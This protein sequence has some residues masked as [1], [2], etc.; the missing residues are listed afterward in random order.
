MT[1]DDIR[2][3]FKKKFNSNVA[4]L[5]K[6][7]EKMEEEDGRELKSIK[8]FASSKP[9]NFP[10]D[11]LLTTLG[12]MFEKPDIQAQIWRNQRSVHGLAKVKAGKKSKKCSWSSKSQELE[13]VGILWCADNHIYNNTTDFV[14][15]EE[16][17]TY[18][19]HS[20]LKSRRRVNVKT[21]STLIKIQK[22]LVK[23]KEAADVDTIVAT[24]TTESEYVAAAYCCG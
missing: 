10:D 21:A 4:F 5:E 13:A 11:F 3:I 1:Y 9:N 2:P 7:R 8:R 14:S 18:Q 17:S 24:S 6:I 15:R 22:P 20:Q 19:V 16:V 12:A 23:D